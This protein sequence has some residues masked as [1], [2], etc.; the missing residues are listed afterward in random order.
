M[1]TTEIMEQPDVT[2][3]SQTPAPSGTC[4]EN[5]QSHF[6]SKCPRASGCD[7]ATDGSILG[8][9]ADYSELEKAY[10]ALQSEFTRKCQTLAQM[11]Q[12]NAGAA[13]CDKPVVA[14]PAP[15]PSPDEIIKSYL[16]S[17]AAK[18]T[19]P[20]VITNTS[21]F[22]LGTKPAP[23]SLRDIETVAEQF[24]KNKEYPK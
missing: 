16:T 23:R 4:A 6:R 8:K 17:V 1:T 5:M 21:D 9:F 22:A 14:E 19:A 20:A 10:N 18:Q 15:T 2:P 3:D 7:A 12:G 13:V 11:Q 24:F